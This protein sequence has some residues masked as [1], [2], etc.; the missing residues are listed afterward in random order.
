MNVDQR[1]DII[2][3][4][5]RQKEIKRREIIKR[6]ID[7]KSGFERLAKSILY[8][9]DENI[10]NLEQALN[11]ILSKDRESFATQIDDIQNQEK[12]PACSGESKEDAQTFLDLLQELYESYQYWLENH[13][14]VSERDDLAEI[15][16][17]DFSIQSANE[18]EI[19]PIKNDIELT[20]RL[21]ELFK[22]ARE[23]NRHPDADE[24]RDLFKELGIDQE[25]TIYQGLLELALR[26]EKEEVDKKLREQ[27]H[28]IEDDDDN[29]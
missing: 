13:N 27:M 29:T 18:K 21:G 16:K 12:S 3:L 17:P 8:I 19:K 20:S 14:K 28:P 15:I 5:A 24:F 10:E 6:F 4:F 22:R 9:I 25:S 2:D 11:R 7:S 1:G 23:Q 26:S